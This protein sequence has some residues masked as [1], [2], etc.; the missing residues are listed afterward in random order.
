MAADARTSSGLKSRQVIES[1]SEMREACVRM[2]EAAPMTAPRQNMFSAHARSALRM[3]P[4]GS[5]L[6]TVSWAK[7][8]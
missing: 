3:R 4:V 8:A 7:P 1:F 6:L 5:R 2:L